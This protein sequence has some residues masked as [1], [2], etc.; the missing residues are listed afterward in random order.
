MD[1]FDAWVAQTI[2]I[3]LHETYNGSPV[4]DKAFRVFMARSLEHAT[5]MRRSVPFRI[6]ALRISKTLGL[7]ITCAILDS[8]L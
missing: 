8:N 4:D 3:N 1:A 6:V 2:R 7:S 5:T